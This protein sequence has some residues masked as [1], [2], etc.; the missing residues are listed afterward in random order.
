VTYQL[1][2]QSLGLIV[3]TLLARAGVPPAP[4]LIGASVIMSVHVHRQFR[5]AYGLRPFSAFWRM[6]A[7]TFVF[8]TAVLIFLL[9]L[10][11]LG[12]VG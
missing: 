5:D 11:A 9:A 12:A 1:S 6:T 10:I 2:F 4:L 3:V 7:F 8:F